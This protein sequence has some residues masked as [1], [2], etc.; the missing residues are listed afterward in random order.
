MNDLLST[1]WIL[2][3]EVE[4]GLVNVV[5]IDGPALRRVGK[6]LLKFDE[7]FE[8]VVVEWIG[9]AHFAAGIKLVVPCLAGLCA[10]LKEQHHGFYT[11]ALKG[12]TGTVKNGMEVAAFQKK[13]S[14]AGGRIVG[15]GK[16][17]VLDDYAC[18]A[19]CLEHFDEVLKE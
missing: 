9:L 17:G 5:G 4:C 8:V 13:F 2:H 14:Q 6:G 10:L 19:S 1:V 18:A 12:A 3:G 7:L 11:S 15:I 16:E